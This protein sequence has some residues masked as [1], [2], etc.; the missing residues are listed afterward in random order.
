MSF[1]PWLV[2][3]MAMMETTLLICLV[4]PTELTIIIATVFALEGYFPFT[5]V[6]FAAL[7]GAILGD[8]FGFLVDRWGGR[9]LLGGSGRFARSV[10]RYQ[11]CASVLSHRYPVFA[12]S[13]ARLIPFVRTVMPPLAG[14]TPVP[15]YRFLRFD[16]LG[17][18]G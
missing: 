17:V 15:Y 2:G 10:R 5:Q 14:S 3:G 1:G 9:S 18:A 4:L 11:D 12:V 7:L 6:V 16:L 13:L 8:S